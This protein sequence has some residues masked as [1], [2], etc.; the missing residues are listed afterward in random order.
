MKQV[1]YH[2]TK[3]EDYRNGM[4]NEIKEG[5]KERINKAIYLL[6]NLDLLYE[7][8]K[9][10]TINWKHC[11]EQNLTNPIINHQAFLGQTACNIYANIKEDETREAWGFLTNEQRYSANRI[12]DKVYQEWKKQYEKNKINSQLFLF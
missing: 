11:T 6:T 10:V 7:N 2:Y 4:Y 3:W 9:K 5:R 12:A 1:W 8:M